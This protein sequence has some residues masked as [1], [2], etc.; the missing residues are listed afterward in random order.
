MGPQAWL[1]NYLWSME[2]SCYITS[3]V[4]PLAGLSTWVWSQAVVHQNL[5]T[6]CCKPHPSSPSLIPSGQALQTPPVSSMIQDHTTLGELDIH[7]GLSSHWRKCR[8]RLGG[9]SVKLGGKA[10][11]MEYN[12]SSY[13]S[14]VVFLDLC[15][16]GGTSV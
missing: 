4:V 8:L 9:G 12:S 3:R 16:P 6:G 11:W 7:L 1:C 14:N 10:M 15:Y 2:V 13:S 5:S